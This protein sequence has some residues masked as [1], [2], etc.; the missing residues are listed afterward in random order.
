ME[1]KSDYF[2][3]KKIKSSSVVQ[4][5]IDALTQAMIDKELRPGDKIPTELELSE[6]LGV[7]RLSVREAIKVLVY[8]GVL[9]IRR[10]EGTFVCSGISD[11]MIDPM[12][13]GIILHDDDSYSSIKELRQMMEVGVIKLAMHK[14]TA[15]DRINLLEKYDNFKTVLENEP[16]N[17]DAVFEADNEFHKVV[18]EI[19]GNPVIDRINSLVRTLTYDMRYRTVTNMLG[20]GMGNTLLLAHRKIYDAIINRDE[21]NIEEI[22]DN[23]YFYDHVD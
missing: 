11:S 18:S 15:E 10:P 9:E 6:S 5:I 1:R 4:Q 23:G 7:G 8:Y 20:A 2:Q 17:I 21:K 3:N 12:L 22:V 13:Y 14:Y 16:V 19:G